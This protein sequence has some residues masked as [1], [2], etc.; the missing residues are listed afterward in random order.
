[1]QTRPCQRAD[2]HN[3]GRRSALADSPARPMPA[4]ELLNLPGDGRQHEL[5]KGTLTSMSGGSWYASRIADRIGRRIGDH[6]EEHDL[7]VTCGA[8][9]GFR[10]SKNPDTVRAPH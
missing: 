6:V 3:V 4:D 7:G 10:L 5:V 2:P 9:C 8:E 1:M